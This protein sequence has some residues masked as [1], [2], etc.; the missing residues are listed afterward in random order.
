[1]KS[2]F[3]SFIVAFSMYSKIPMPHIEWSEKSMKYSMCFF[4]WIGLVIGLLEYLWFLVSGW[5][6][7][8]DLL[9]SAVAV[10]IPLLVTGGIHFDGFLDTT[11]ALSSWR[12]REERLRI[13]KDSH[14]GAFA[15]I[16]ACVYFLTAL[17]F[18]SEVS[19]STVPCLC[20]MFAVS[21]SYSAISV[22]VF[23]NAN[24]KG[25]AAAFGSHSEKKIVLRVMTVYLAVLYV[26]LI[27]IAPL[28]G[29]CV[30]I[31]SVLAFLIYYRT[32]MHYF[33]GM[34]GDLAGFFVSG[35]ELLMLI[36]AVAGDGIG[37]LWLR[38]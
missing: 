25:T 9:R 13:L 35:A 19:G 5:F 32:C 28:T 12:T 37:R 27:L 10:V 2:L 23:P 18:A 29:I 26:C 16:G 14:V 36:L 6:G 31:G 21:R 1:M 33:G 38:G 22:V 20:L 3:E 30:I 4:P 34:T 15:V 8:S 24:P 7:A 11:D 17:G